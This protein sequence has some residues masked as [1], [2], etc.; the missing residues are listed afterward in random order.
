M[1]TNRPPECSSPFCTEISIYLALNPVP[2]SGKKDNKWPMMIKI[3]RLEGG[4]KERFKTRRVS[5]NG[6]LRKVLLSVKKAARVCVKLESNKYYYRVRVVVAHN[7]FN[8]VFFE[9]VL[10]RR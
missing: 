3:K 2:N 8:K 9:L 4:T 10:C 5:E 1:K 6:K 7:R